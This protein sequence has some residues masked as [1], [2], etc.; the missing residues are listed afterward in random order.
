S[1]WNGSQGLPHL[2]LLRRTIQIILA[3]MRDQFRRR[4]LK[5]IQ[6]DCGPLRPLPPRIVQCDGVDPSVERGLAAKVS[7]LL[8]GGS[9]CGGRNIL[10]PSRGPGPRP[11]CCGAT[12]AGTFS[13]TS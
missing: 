5:S 9:K 4:R 11:S 3:I 1:R 12:A 7:E 13:C 6:G 2:E 8:E 10:G